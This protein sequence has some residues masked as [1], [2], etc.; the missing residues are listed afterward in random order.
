MNYTGAPEHNAMREGDYKLR[1]FTNGTVDYF[2][3]P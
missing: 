3:D 1:F 2:T